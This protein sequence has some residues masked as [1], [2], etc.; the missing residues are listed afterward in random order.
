[1]LASAVLALVLA[2]PPAPG[3][4][5]VDVLDLDQGTLLVSEPP[6]DGEDVSQWSAFRASDGDPAQGWCSAEGKPLGGEFVYELAGDAEVKT[7][8]VSAAGVQ[9]DAYPGVSVRG[10]ELWTAGAAGPFTRAGA[11]EVPKGG[12]KELALPAGKPVRKVKV[13]VKSNWGNATYTELMEL[14][15]LGKWVAPPPAFDASGDYWSE[16]W[17]GFRLKQTGS[18]V[19]GCYDYA[20]GTFSGDMEGR[21]ARGA[22]RETDD[23]GKNEHGG[24]A[25]F[26]V[27]PDRR[28]I[29][30]VYFHQDGNEPGSWNLR[31]PGEDEVV[32]CQPKGSSLADRL[33]REG[34]LALYGIH[35][36]SASDVPRADSQPTLEQLL[37]VLKAEPGLKLQVEGHT[38]STNTDAYNL[39]L[40]ERR[41]R[42]VAKWL[43]D[44]GVAADRLA[45][46]GYGRTRPVA[47]NGTSQGR[48]LNRRVEVALPGK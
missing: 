21:V 28:M 7:F 24:R 23:E 5:L 39:D 26:V 1:M 33:K 25:T 3:S 18:H 34:R 30:G 16:T 46:R 17:H 38:D 8:R 4:D 10:V 29:R 14:D 12:A 13:V 37:A 48:A 31:K 6:S 15:L 9:E 45:P 2:A 19:E 43:A 36:D 42:A 11:L 35:F 22:W 47:S 41:A 44:H 20:H 40:S 32:K 27:S